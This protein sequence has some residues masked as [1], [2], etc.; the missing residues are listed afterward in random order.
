MQVVSVKNKFNT[1]F[2]SNNVTLKNI[3]PTQFQRYKDI[4]RIAKED[5]LDIFITKSSESEYLDQ[6]DLYTIVAKRDVLCDVNG[7][8]KIEI[9][10]HRTSSVLTDKQA[11][12]KEVSDKLYE[13]VVDTI[14]SLA[15]NIEKRVGKRPNFWHI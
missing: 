11:S 7:L 12:A 13:S 3:D 6:N 1:M 10:A 8:G 15:K 9:P 2:G 4:Q 14:E 5:K